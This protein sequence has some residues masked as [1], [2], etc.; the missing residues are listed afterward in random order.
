MRDDYRT[1]DGTPADDTPVE[2]EDGDDGPPPDETSAEADVDEDPPDATPVTDGD[3]DGE[4]ET[5]TEVDGGASYH[6]ETCD[7]VFEGTNAKERYAAHHNSLIHRRNEADAEAAQTAVGPGGSG[8]GNESESGSGSGR[9]TATASG[10]TAV[11]ATFHSFLRAGRQ[12]GLPNL[13]SPTEEGSSYDGAFSYSIEWHAFFFGVAGGLWAAHDQQTA[14]PVLVGLIA[15][16]FGAEVTA[17]ATQRVPAYIRQYVQREV[18]YFIGGVLVGWALIM[19]L[20][21]EAPVEIPSDWL[22]FGD[23]SH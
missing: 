22:P 17:R 8:S 4:T 2:K 12:A 9:A 14:I 16:A 11:L 19:Y 5:E 3:G 7:Q 18:H 13:D 21:G 15:L 1:Q 10:L 23:H 6:C 20:H